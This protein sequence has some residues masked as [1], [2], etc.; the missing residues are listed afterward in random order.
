MIRGDKLSFNKDPNVGL[1]CFANDKFCLIG[2]PV[3]S[4]TEERLKNVLQV[5]IHHVHLCGTEL[6]GVFV[7][8]NNNKIF[9]PDII[10]PMEEK[11]LKELGIEF[12]KVKTR[13]TALGN[14]ILMN[15][16]A[17]IINPEYEM[18][19]DL[20]I[21]ATRTHLAGLDIIGSSAAMN[22][23]GLLVNRNASEKDIETLKKT[24]N[25]PVMQ[26]TI[27]GGNP[28]VHSGLI[29]NKHGFIVGDETTGSEIL[30]LH[31]IFGGEQ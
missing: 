31:E 27:N 24:F 10:L 19:V 25:L 22:N 5:P 14:N 18:S 1:Y 29:V 21:N 4:K 13:L 12:E 9:V 2:S 17:A 30:K 15:D 23:K 20:G 6:V 7:V 3:E 16:K 8:G 11:R 26:G 28:F